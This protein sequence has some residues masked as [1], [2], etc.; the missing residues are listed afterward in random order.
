[1]SSARVAMSFAERFRGES[2][3]G[4]AFMCARNATRF[5]FQFNLI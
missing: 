5:R 4:S 1:M 2:L 3:A